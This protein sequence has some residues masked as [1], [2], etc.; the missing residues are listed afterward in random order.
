MPAIT[1][2]SEL[3]AGIAAGDVLGAHHAFLDDEAE[4]Q[5]GDRQVHALDAQRRQADQDA[6]DAGHQRRH[7][8]RKDEGPAHGLQPGLGVGA[9]G[10]EAGVAERHLAGEA[11]QQHQAEADDGVDADEAELRQ[12]IFRQH[13]GRGE[14]GHGQRG[15]PELL[16][17][18]LEQRDVLLVAG[19][20]QEMH[21][22]FFVRFS[23]NR[24]LGLTTSITSTTT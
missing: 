23:P 18:V 21:Q 1:S 19:F 16:A 4:G 15:V 9:H 14:Q 12:R 24:P 5:R 17:A 13:E 2:F 22:T 6:G 7:G 3:A 8:Q 10:E 20:E 11:G